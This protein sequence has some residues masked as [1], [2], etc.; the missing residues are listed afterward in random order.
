MTKYDDLAAR[1]G[2][3]LAGF[4]EGYLKLFKNGLELLLVLI[5]QVL[6]MCHIAHILDHHNHAGYG[7]R[8]DRADFP[9]IGAVTDAQH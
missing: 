1:H 2:V 4:T 9:G 5:Q 8:N 6:H 3:E 7:G